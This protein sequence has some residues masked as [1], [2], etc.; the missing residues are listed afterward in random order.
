MANK[1]KKE[2]NN[3]I[4]PQTE[5]EIA[6]MQEESADAV[7]EDLAPKTETDVNMEMGMPA[8][9]PDIASEPE[10]ATVKKPAKRKKKSDAQNESTEESV[11]MPKKKPEK[12]RASVKP[13][14]VISIDEQRSVETEADKEKNDLIDLM[15]S[16]RVGKVLAGTIQGVERSSDNHSI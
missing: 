16:L 9:N 4:E 2:K 11:A 6:A 13:I 12:K 8:A 15:E 3:E 10:E 7:A 5:I 14:Q 1:T